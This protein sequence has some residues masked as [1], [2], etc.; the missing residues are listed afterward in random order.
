MNSPSQPPKINY[1][2][3]ISLF[4]S[5]EVTDIM[6]NSWDKI[7]VEHNG[8]TLL[9]NLKFEDQ[10]AFDYFIRCILDLQPDGEEKNK[11]TFDGM[12]PEGYRFNITLPPVTPHGSTMTIRKFSQKIFTL[13]DLISK[14]SLSDKAALFLKEAVL[15]K[16]TIVISGGTG[17]GKTS[18]INTLSHFIPGA[19]RVVSIEDTQELRSKHPNWVHMVTS[20]NNTARDC[21]VN[22]LRMRPDR[23]IV[24]ECRGPEAY[25]FLQAINTG[26]EGSFTSIHANSAVDCLSRLE[27]L[28]TLGHHDIPLKF[29]RHQIAS[30][31]DL[32]VQLRRLPTGQRQVVDI[33]ELTGMETDIITRASI[34]SWDKTTQKLETTGYVPDCLNKMNAG[35]SNIS[36][37]FFENPQ[38]TVRTA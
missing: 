35:N 26:H 34:F 27:N 36:V 9:T 31:V 8:Q 1:G 30:S 7:F 5:D 28:I 21:L 2:P 12:L 32:I 13:D 23:I 18:F 4:K 3:L 16:L 11:F 10:K 38:N 20:K 37:S 24:G 33:I 6:I 14:G 17:T 22:S 29:I 15:N 19:E 25:D